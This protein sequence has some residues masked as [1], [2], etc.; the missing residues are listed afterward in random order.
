MHVR[1]NAELPRMNQVFALRN[2]VNGAPPKARRRVWGNQGCHWSGEFM[3][4][5]KPFK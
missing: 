1:E 2:C 5:E 4:P 3:E